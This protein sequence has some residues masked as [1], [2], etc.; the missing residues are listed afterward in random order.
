MDYRDLIGALAQLTNYTRT[1]NSHTTHHTGNNV[2][3]P[4]HPI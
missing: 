1:I 4:S 3:A 2:R